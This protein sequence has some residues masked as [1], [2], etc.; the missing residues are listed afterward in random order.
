M[1]NDVINRALEQ[2]ECALKAGDHATALSAA[3]AVLQENPQHRDGLYLK[4]VCQRYLGNTKGALQTLTALQ[5][6]APGYGRGFQELGHCQLMM[7]DLKQ[8]FKAYKKATQLNPGLI[9]SWQ[10]LEQLAKQM[11][12]RK[13]HTK[14]SSQLAYFNRLPPLLLSIT[15]MLSEGKLYK[16]ENLCRQF[17]QEHKHHPEAMRL[18]AK[19][20]TQLH[21]LDD[22]EFLLESCVQLYPEFAQARL[23]LVN[24]LQKRQ[25]YE[26]ALTQATQLYEENP[27]DRQF[28][29]TYANAALAVGDFDTALTTYD[30]LLEQEPKNAVTWLMKGHALKTIGK[31][32]EA[33]TSYQKAHTLKPQFGDA[34]WSLANLKTY[35]FS[36]QEIAAMEKAEAQSGLDNADHYHLCFALG[37]CYEDR[38]EFEKSFEYYERGNL[39]KKRQSDYSASATHEEFERQKAIVD[40]KLLHDDSQGY[41]APDPIFIVGLPRAGSTLLE[42]ILASHSMVDGTLELPNILAFA[43]RLNGRRRTDEAPRYPAVLQTMGGEELEKLGKQF[44]DDTQIY[45][46]GAPFFTDKMPNNFRHIGLILKILPNAKIIDARRHPMAC[47]FSGYKQLFAE[48][49]EFTYSQEDVA[50]YYRDYVALMDHWDEVAPGKILR[51]YHEKLVEHTEPQI[52][53]ILDFCGLPFEDSCLAFHKTERAVRTAS[54]EQVRQP[55]YTSGLAQW[56]NFEAY[57][58]PMQR[59]LTPLIEA[60][61]A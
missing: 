47:C 31:H 44:I 7:G 54:S 19:I 8:A 61:P 11:D 4:A 5:S 35:R 29:S 52:R 46:K 30:A 48:G 6:A 42:Q 53:R 40:A 45:R 57:L 49:Q 59:Q 15:S 39:L 60:Y 18:L 16:A 2:S 17:L 33:V 32:E 20:G 36:A 55:I 10:R 1:H 12:L 23:D 13:E 34:W 24:V 9:A 37:R 56:K 26:K 28:K 27:V 14:A 43:H 41:E 50:Q 38:G 22:A 25:K 51:V 58:G 21:I 3:D